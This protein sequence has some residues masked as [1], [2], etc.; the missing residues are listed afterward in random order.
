MCIN[1]LKGQVLIYYTHLIL[2]APIPFLTLPGLCL[3]WFDVADVVLQVDI[4]DGISKQVTMFFCKGCGKYQAA[5]N[6]W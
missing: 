5:T 3:H 2:N 4:T 6:A 1:C